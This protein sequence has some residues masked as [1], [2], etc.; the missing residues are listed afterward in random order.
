MICGLLWLLLTFGV[1]LKFRNIKS[2]FSEKKTKHCCIRNLFYSLNIRVHG[3]QWSWILLRT[4]PWQKWGKCL[5]LCCFIF[6]LEGVIWIWIFLHSI[7]INNVLSSSNK[8]KSYWG[9]LHW[10]PSAKVYGV[11]SSRD[12]NEVKGKLF[13]DL[14][15]V[16]EYFLHFFYFLKQDIK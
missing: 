12:W 16:R 11:T 8:S 15:G 3:W 7:D 2:T 1:H 10:L 9:I 14:S 6:R 13:F 4:F 5:F